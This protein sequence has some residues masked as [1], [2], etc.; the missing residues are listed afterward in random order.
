MVVFVIKWVPPSVGWVS[1]HQRMEVILV[2]ENVFLAV[3]LWSWWR[4]RVGGVAA[5]AQQW[6]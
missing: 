3:R 1:Y 5:V 6:A 4:H 2:T